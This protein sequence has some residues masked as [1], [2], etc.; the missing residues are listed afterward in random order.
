MSGLGWPWNMVFGY[1]VLLVRA[2]RWLLATGNRNPATGRLPAWRI[3]IAA[4]LVLI[5]LGVSA[6]ALLAPPTSTG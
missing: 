2:I 4:A 6:L 3:A 5:V 1:T